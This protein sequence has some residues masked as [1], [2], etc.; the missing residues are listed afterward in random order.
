VPV[1]T[2]GAG[3]ISDVISDRTNGMILQSGSSSEL[4]CAIYEL[5]KDKAL[6]DRIS[7]NSRQTI[8]TAYS[9][10]TMCKQYLR[11]YEEACGQ[12]FNN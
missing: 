4:A 8:L 11:A 3:G 7:A 10:D 5:I 1:I 9:D 12:P 2:S 6:V